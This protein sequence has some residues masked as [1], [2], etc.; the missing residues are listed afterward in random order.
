MKTFSAQNKAIQNSRE[1][2][3]D[4]ICETKMIK[5]T[6]PKLYAINTETHAP[7]SHSIRVLCLSVL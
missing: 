4:S 5:T 1:W 7:M 3:K 2:T 6:C